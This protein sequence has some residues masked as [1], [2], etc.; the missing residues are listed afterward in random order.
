[1]DD[2]RHIYYFPSLKHNIPSIHIGL[3][4]ISSHHKKMVEA[5]VLMDHNQQDEGWS[6]DILYEDTCI[7]WLQGHQN[8]WSFRSFKLCVYNMM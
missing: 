4:V 8:Q 2:T 7:G 1:M 3:S 5:Y 6:A